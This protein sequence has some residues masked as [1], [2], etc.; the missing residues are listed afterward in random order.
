MLHTPGFNSAGILKKGQNRKKYA[1]GWA[2][3]ITKD[4]HSSPIYYCRKVPS[5]QDFI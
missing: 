4:S 5:S 1:D 3:S 2:R